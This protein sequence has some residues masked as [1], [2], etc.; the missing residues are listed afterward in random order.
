MKIFVSYAHDDVG[1]RL[2]QELVGKLRG[3]GYSVTSDRDMPEANPA[4][5]QEWMRE[6]IA[7]GIVLCVLSPDYVARFAT[8]S[9]SSV[10]SGVL[11]ESRAIVQRLYEFTEK[12]NCPIIPVALPD[13]GI[14]VVPSDL[15]RLVISK[16]DVDD[17]ALFEGLVKR[18]MALENKQ[19]GANVPGGSSPSVVPPEPLALAR[20]DKGM[21]RLRT[22]MHDLETTAPDSAQALD[23]V[24]EWLALSADPN[25]CDTWFVNA[26]PFAERVA[27]STGDIR[28]MRDLSDTCLRV[29]AAAEPKLKTEYQ[30]EARV[31]ICGRGWH[32]Q[33]DHLLDEA[34]DAN[35]RGIQLAEKYEDARTE[36]FGKKCL[37]RIQRILAEEAAA[38]EQAHLLR[39]SVSS[40]V[41]A[42]ELFARIAGT[43]DAE[44]GDCFSLEA[45]THLVRYQLTSNE[46][47]LRQSEE[48]LVAAERILAPGAS[49]DYLDFVILKAE[50][51]LVNDKFESGLKLVGE[52]I[53]R[54]LSRQGAQYSEI[55]A[56]AYRVRASLRLAAQGDGGQEYAVRDFERAADIFS[57]LGQL[58]A[59]AL[60]EWDMIPLER[61]AWLSLNV[62]REELG[63]LARQA[64]DPRERLDALRELDRQEHDR[65]GIRV[66]TRAWEV[67]WP[68][69][70]KKLR[71][72]EE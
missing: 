44:V 30:L 27:K 59:A 21:S 68:S 14:K 6:R 16:I 52:A 31:L 62:P 12:D 57:K 40:L 33:R 70:L 29:L 17:D 42:R 45:R 13:F 66:A 26:F 43:R 48:A 36:A 19:S 49:K 22:V 9:G 28:L 20:T 11:Y 54:L 64:R 37:G 5:M 67:N 60:C 4:S 61:P 24:H 63:E 2:E 53:E 23:L 47:A 56:R 18:I 15:C 55:L 50:L 39:E 34:M 69:I 3:R 51:E 32:L 46:D 38:P 65:M 10:R 7:E 25:C 71:S 8:G 1:K 35:K 41:K 58:H 72:R